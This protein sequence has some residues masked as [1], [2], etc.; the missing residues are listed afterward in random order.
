MAT[1]TVTVLFT[2]LVG[3]T[4]LMSRVGEQRAAE[5]RRE[6]FA[7]TRAAVTSMAGREVKNLG[8]GL[9]V[10]FDGAT[11][12][13][14]CAVDIQCSFEERNRGNPEQLSM[15]IG[16]ATGEADIEEQDYFGSPVVAASRLCATTEGGEYT[17]HQHRP[18]AG[19]ITG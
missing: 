19:R 2:D 8:D 3:S 13:L 15:R 5:L 1:A 16:V 9:M 7:L 14:S 18:G 6:Q 10:V 12:A 17:R 4:A 11:A